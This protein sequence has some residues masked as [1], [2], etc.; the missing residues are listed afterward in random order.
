MNDRAIVYR[1][2]YNI[3]TEWGTAVNVQAM[4]YG[5]TGEQLRLRRRV[6]AQSGQRR[7]MSSTA[8]FS[9]TRRAK[10]SSPACARP[11]PLPQLKNE[12]PKPF[13]ELEKSA[14]TLEKHFKD[15]QDIEFTIQDGKLFMLQTRNGKRTGARRASK[16]A[17]DMVKEKLIDWKTAVL[18]ESGRPARPA[19][20]ADLRLAEAEEAPRSSPPV[21]PPA[22]ARPPAK[23][24]STPTA[25]STAA[26]QGRESSARPQRDFARRFARH[27]RRRRHSH[28][29]R[30]RQFARGARR[31]P[32]GQG[33]RLRRGGVADRLRSQK[34]VTVDGQ[35]FKEGDFL[36]IDGTAG[37]VYAG[38]I[39]T[40]PSEIIAG[41]R[42]EA[43]K[44]PGHSKTFKMLQAAHEL[45]RA[46]PRRLQVRTNADTPE[47]T[48]ERRRVR[49]DRHRPDAAPSTCSSRATASTRCAR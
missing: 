43:L 45:V 47:Q 22:P 41:A 18:R 6:H 12:M 38:Q 15:V 7:R 34:T 11:S 8:N 9:S 24:I 4:V 1:R 31:P 29:E 27:D 32:D 2:K 44:P 35:T 3:P 5:N 40:A 46:R 17:M 30:R 36:S 21:C 25:P 14:Q 19:A 23:S 13:A 10:T 42:R 16:F 37:K 39:K 48:A 33:L 26:E 28:R 20:R 49:R